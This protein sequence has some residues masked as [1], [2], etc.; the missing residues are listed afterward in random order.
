[1]LSCFSRVDSLRPYGPSPTRLLFPWD[2]PGKNTGVGCH[3][4]HQGIFPTWGMNSRLPMSPELQVGSLHT[5]P[6]GKPGQ[7][8]RAKS[9]R[10][11]GLRASEGHTWTHWSCPLSRVELSAYHSLA[12]RRGPATSKVPRVPQ[13][14]VESLISTTS[15]PSPQPTIPASTE[16][17]MGTTC[18]IEGSEIQPSLCDLTCCLNSGC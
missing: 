2:P 6:P 3:A 1:M 7:S 5:E 12:E 11:L 10:G 8:S 13:L 15:N 9:N 18:L 16:P 4:L 17:E 14:S